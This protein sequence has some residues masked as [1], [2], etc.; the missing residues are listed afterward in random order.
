MFLLFLSGQAFADWSGYATVTPENLY[1]LEVGA[2]LSKETGLCTIRIRPNDQDNLQAWFFR[3][4]KKLSPDEA[5]IGD[6]LRRRNSSPPNLLFLTKIRPLTLPNDLEVLDGNTSEITIE[7][8]LTEAA[9]VYLGYPPT[10]EVLDGG[11]RYSIHLA[12]FCS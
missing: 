4:A 8:E 12:L 10:I 7:H 1:D 9:Y 6:Y 3:T 2:E 11:Y 5:F